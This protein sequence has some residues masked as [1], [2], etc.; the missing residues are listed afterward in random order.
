MERQQFLDG[1]LV[2]AHAAEG[3]AILL[4]PLFLAVVGLVGWA[5]TSTDD[6]RSRTRT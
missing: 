2:T 4:I 6:E 3:A 5:L 1:R